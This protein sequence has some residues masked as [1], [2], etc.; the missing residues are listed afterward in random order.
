M[1]T[2][3]HYGGDSNP[4]EP[5]KI[6]DYYNL[7]FKLG[8]AVKYILRY[9]RKGAPIQD[10][11]KAINCINKKLFQMKMRVYL[12]GA[13]SA[14]PNYATKF[15]TY[16]VMLQRMFP[17][18][19]IISPASDIDHSGHDKTWKAYMRADLEIMKTCNHIALIP[20]WNQS[21]GARMEYW[22]SNR[23]GMRWI[24]LPQIE[25]VEADWGC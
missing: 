9:N 1:N 25:R 16:K 24:L 18:A 11:E 2:P 13:I 8:N 19:T 23:W 22:L 12:S 10:L 20:D 3:S 7:D 14:D 5:I 15:A 17:D 6:I 21:R 4:F